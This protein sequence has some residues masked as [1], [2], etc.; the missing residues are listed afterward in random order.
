VALHTL[1]L[2]KII[3]SVLMSR[4][5]WHI[6]DGSKGLMARGWWYIAILA[7]Y[8]G[9]K[10]GLQLTRPTIVY[11]QRLRQCVSVSYGNLNTVTNNLLTQPFIGSPASVRWCEGVRNTIVFLTRWQR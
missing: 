4:L 3:I 10:L 9:L 7:Y 1:G 5:C 11:Q 6:V 8:S 2:Q